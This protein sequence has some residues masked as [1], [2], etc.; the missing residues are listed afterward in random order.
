MLRST[1]LLLISIYKKVKVNLL[2]SSP[3]CSSL[4]LDAFYSLFRAERASARTQS[5]CKWKANGIYYK[6]FLSFSQVSLSLSPSLPLSLSF[7]SSQVYA[8]R[9]APLP[10]TVCCCYC[11]CCHCVHCSLC[12]RCQFYSSSRQSERHF[13]PRDFSHLSFSLFCDSTVPDVDDKLH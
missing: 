1:S 12:I 10:A 3:S 5:A 2:L 11:R 9:D 7:S 8:L 13:L 4:L 6:S